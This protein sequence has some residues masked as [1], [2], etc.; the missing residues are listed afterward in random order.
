MEFEKRV[1][2]IG[3]CVLS[4][5]AG[6][7]ALAVEDCCTNT[8][9]RQSFRTELRE[10]TFCSV[11]W[12][13]T[14]QTDGKLCF[15]I[16]TG[17]ACGVERSL[18]VGQEY[19]LSAEATVGGDAGGVTV[20]VSTTL[21]VSEETTHTAGPCQSCQFFASYGNAS[22]ITWTVQKF[23]V[24]GDSRSTR[25]VFYNNG[26]APTI[27]P[28]CEENTNCPG[29]RTPGDGHGDDPGRIDLGGFPGLGGEPFPMD[30]RGSDGGAGDGHAGRGA[31]P[32]A[33][34]IVDLRT[35]DMHFLFGLPAWH[36]MN[37]PG[38]TFATLNGWQ[39]QAIMRDV[40]TH[41]TIDPLPVTEL[42]VIDVD[43]TPHMF[44]LLADPAGL[45]PCPADVT[46][47]GV[48]DLSDV[49][50]FVNYFVFGDDGADLDYNGV[51][52]LGDVGLFTSGFLGA[53]P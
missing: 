14:H 45:V 28:C 46:C 15:P 32:G 12:S 19:T 31:F 24:W 47:D 22:V 48:L 41:Q 42:A 30:R 25:T 50:L 36:P 23:C 38:T 37:A 2:G 10:G 5:L 39:K 9:V 17:Y 33:T 20:G 44:D 3:A 49:S 52:D 26:G 11:L 4:L 7:A 51:L 43:G 8:A 1:C 6:H 27:M 34:V 18:V 40:L 29:C 16:G 21:T 35:P 13:A 53:C